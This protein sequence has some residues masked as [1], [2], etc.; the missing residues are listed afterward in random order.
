MKNSSGNWSIKFLYPL[1]ACLLCAAILNG[2][3]LKRVNRVIA[4]IGQEVITTVDLNRMVEPSLELIRSQFTGEE[5]AQ[6]EELARRSALQRL[7]SDKLLLIEANNLKL[8][9]PE[10][11]ITK[12]LNTIKS[13][14]AT[15]EDFMTSLKE[16]KMKMAELRKVVEDE[17]KNRVLLQDKVA[18][19]IRVLPPEIHDYY[20]LNVSKYLQPSNV[21]MFQILVKKR[22][23]QLKASLRINEIEAELKSGADF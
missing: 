13:Q 1:C 16:R 11:E 7:I 6:Q 18:K 10:V 22:P 2:A 17:I 12:R 3:E 4:K 14:F 15:E 9:I 21:H 23:D 5:R 19:R 20:Q 8:E